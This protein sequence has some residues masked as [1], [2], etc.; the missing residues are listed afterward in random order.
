MRRLVLALLILSSTAFAGTI[1]GVFQGT[2]VQITAPQPQAKTRW[3]YVQGKNGV[4]RRANIAKANFDYDEEY[5]KAKRHKKPEESLKTTATVRVTAEQDIAK[6]GDW[7]ATKVSFV[8]PDDP[9]KHAP[10]STAK[11]SAATPVLA[12]R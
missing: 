11:P 7:Q 4:I 8:W 6:G 9:T 3:M 12:K 10:K 1:T 2:V 5:P